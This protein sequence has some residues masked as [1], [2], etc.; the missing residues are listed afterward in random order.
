L[1]YRDEWDRGYA[2]GQ[3]AMLAVLQGRA[4]GPEGQSPEAGKYRLWALGHNLRVVAALAVWSEF[5]HHDYRVP[6][7]AGGLYMARAI[8]ASLPPFD[9]EFPW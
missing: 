5:N 1:K 9:K 2:A 3:Q 8:R 7:N 4:E 6:G